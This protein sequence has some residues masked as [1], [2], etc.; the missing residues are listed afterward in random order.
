MPQKI[1]KQYYHFSHNIAP[2]SVRIAA[3]PEGKIVA[4]LLNKGDE[5]LPVNF[6]IQGKAGEI[7]LMGKHLATCVIEL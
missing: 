3:T 5:V 7:L 1:Q 4:I 2:G 6:R